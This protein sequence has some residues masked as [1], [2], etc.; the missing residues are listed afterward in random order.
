MATAVQQWLVV[1]GYQSFGGTARVM[2]QPGRERRLKKF[3]GSNGIALAHL[4][5]GSTGAA[6]LLGAFQDVAGEQECR[7]RFRN[8]VIVPVRQR[9]PVLQFVRS[10]GRRR[11]RC[12]AA[13]RFRRRW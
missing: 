7:K 13:W 4:T 10:G 5:C 11:F 9:A 6:P 1:A 3:P 12:N 8:I 2:Y